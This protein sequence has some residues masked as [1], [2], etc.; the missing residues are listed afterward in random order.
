MATAQIVLGARANGIT[1]HPKSGLRHQQVLLALAA[2]TADENVE[3]DNPGWDWM[4]LTYWITTSAGPIVVTVYCMLFN[5]ITGDFDNT[6]TLANDIFTGATQPAFADTDSG[7]ITQRTM[8]GPGA[9]TA[10]WNGSGTTR[11]RGALEGP[12]P[13]RFEL[14]FKPADATSLTYG[15][16][17]DMGMGICHAGP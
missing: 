17:A 7:G 9:S 16:Y 3:I 13:P 8:M 5:P 2:R 14:Y 15:V 11:M 12:L 10:L 1:V 4:A 6:G